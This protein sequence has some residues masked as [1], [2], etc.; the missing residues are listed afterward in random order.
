[1]RVGVAGPIATDD[2]RHLLDST[3]E[4]LPRGSAG[5]PLMATLINALLDQGNEV[6]AFTMDRDLHPSSETPIMA[7]G[8]RFTIYYV[9]CRRRSIRFNQGYPG[10]IV[11]LYRLERRR[12][13]VA[14][15]GD[16]CDVIHAHWSYEF[17]LAALDS[18]KPTVVTCHD[19]PWRVLRYMPNVYRF[20]RLLMAREALRRAAVVTSV[21]PHIVAELQ[22]MTPNPIR[23]I[24]NPPPARVEGRG[25]VRALPAPLR[26]ARLVMI[27]NGFDKRK[28][29]QPALRAFARVREKLPFA[30]LH[31]FGY[32]FGADEQAEQWCRKQGL[33]EGVRFH[34]LRRHDEVLAALDVAELLVHPALEESCCMSIVEAMTLG[35]PVVAGASSG[36]VPWQLDQGRAGVM[37]DVRSAE[38][39]ADGVMS[40]LANGTRYRELSVAALEHAGKLFATDAV[41][42]GYSAAYRDA[43]H[44]WGDRGD[45][46]RSLNPLPKL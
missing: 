27:L 41:I 6:C 36:G 7:S 32:G 8:P 21:S 37:V 43:I 13:A 29:P 30:E 2:V 42:A 44:S 14:M 1:M 16:P 26:E 10:R 46:S 20:G 45:R 9:P 5:A 28:N 11:D 34:G 24:A 19:S 33:M 31:T 38:E 40:L 22:R 25:R 12:L 17:A 18:G 23:V 35:V 3:S 4:G 15:R 39:I